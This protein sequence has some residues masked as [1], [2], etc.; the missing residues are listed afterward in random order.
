MCSS[1]LDGIGQ[2]GV[3]LALVRHAVRRLGGELTVRSGA[4]G[5]AG[6]IFKVR[7][8]AR[9]GAEPPNSGPGRGGPAVAEVAR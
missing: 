2:R 4:E 6:A 5:S 3:G 1:D 8:P 9:S 7:I